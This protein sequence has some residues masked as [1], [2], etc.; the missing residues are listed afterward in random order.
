V[1]IDP[2]VAVDAIRLVDED[3][4]DSYGPPE[5]NLQRIADMWSGYLNIPITKEDV[6]LMMVLLKISRSKA[7]Y[8]RDNAVDGVA[9]FLIHD[10]M[11]RYEHGHK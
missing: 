10:S 2:T 5:E 7:G 4:N 3:R 6:S 1:V 8:C 11:A 9:Y